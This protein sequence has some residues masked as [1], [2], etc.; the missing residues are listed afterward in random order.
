[1]IKGSAPGSVSLRTLHENVEAFD[2]MC[3]PVEQGGQRPLKPPP[4][5][6]ERNR[7]TAA[8]LALQADKRAGV[9]A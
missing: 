7:K 8:A 3:L 5:N 9:W 6:F 4:Y 2:R 1:M